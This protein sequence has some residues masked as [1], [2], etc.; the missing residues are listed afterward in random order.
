MKK[1]GM[2]IGWEWV[3]ERLLE[4]EKIDGIGRADSRKVI[5]LAVDR[6]L[7]RAKALARPAMVSVK[8]KIT[9]ISDGSIAVDGPVLSVG[10]R[11]SS[12]FKGATHAHI[13]LVTLG[14]DIEEEASRLMAKGGYLNGYL[15]DRIGSFAVED[16]AGKAEEKLRSLYAS[17]DHSVSGRVSPGYCD[18]P[19]EEQRKL[20]KVLNF[21]AAGVRLTENCMMAPKK[22]IS[23]IIGI[24][25]KGLFPAKSS[26]CAICDEKDCRYRGSS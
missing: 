20:Q 13:F 18:W 15:M 4:K 6:C 16:L 10:K 1:S 3:R 17:R 26:R 24:G 8:R 11:L 21:S 23:A 19:I 25:P 12:Y 5:L 7:K 2:K 22:S 9:N 14:K